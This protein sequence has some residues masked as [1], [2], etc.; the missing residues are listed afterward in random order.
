MTGAIAVEETPLQKLSADL[1]HW[2]RIWQ[3]KPSATLFARLILLEPGFQ[4]STLFRL[5]ELVRRVPIFGAFLDRVLRVLGVILYSADLAPQAR[6]GA[7]IYFPHPVGIVIGA[8]DI[9]RDVAILQGVTLGVAERQ[10]VRRI[11]IGDGTWIYAGAK[12]LG[13][14]EI[15]H[16]V[17]IGAN[18]V[19]LQSVPDGH[20][21]VG[22]PARILPP[23]LDRQDL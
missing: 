16:Q 21:A 4:L 10:I 13:E 15:G 1:R 11:V 23:S 17:K 18:A 20:V 19:V 9:G 8:A 12:V 14:I 7:G 5:R 22:V 6:I 2:A 3:R